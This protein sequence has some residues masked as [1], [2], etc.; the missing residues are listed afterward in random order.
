MG[1]QISQ[2][3][4]QN[5]AMRFFLDVSMRV[6]IV[7]LQGEMGWVPMRVYTRLAVVRF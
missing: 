1:L 3:V 4:I 6:P 2:Q 7:A 5:R